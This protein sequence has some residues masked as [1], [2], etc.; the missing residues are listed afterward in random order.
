MLRREC[1]IVPKGPGLEA[2]VGGPQRAYRV[3]GSGFRSQ[4]LGFR[5]LELY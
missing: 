4:G 3:L 2:D 5:I 1:F